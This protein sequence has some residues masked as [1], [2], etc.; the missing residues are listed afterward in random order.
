MLQCGY[1]WHPWCHRP[2]YLRWAMGW[3]CERLRSNALSALLWS[4]VKCTSWIGGRDAVVCTARGSMCGAVAP[5][6]GKNR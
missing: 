2:P 1:G 5:D 3:V 6:R 4:V